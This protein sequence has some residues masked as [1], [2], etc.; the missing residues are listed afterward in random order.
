[1]FFFHASRLFAARTRAPRHYAALRVLM[2][3]Y[4]TTLIRCLCL[5]AHARHVPLRARA[6]PDARLRCRRCAIPVS[7]ASA[8][9]AT[10]TPIDV[11]AADVAYVLLDAQIRAAFFIDTTSRDDTAMLIL[12]AAF[13]FSLDRCR[14]ATPL[15]D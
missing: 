13:F 14:V 15:P 1:M 2:R 6:M 3:V 9:H 11:A 5:R 12:H 7:D 8:R 4:Y 10:A